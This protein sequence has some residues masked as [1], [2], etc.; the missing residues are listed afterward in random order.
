MAKHHRW[1]PG[2]IAG[3]WRL[4]ALVPRA[5]SKKS[6]SAS[7]GGWWR[8]ICVLCETATREVQPSVE[9]CRSSTG[10]LQCAAKARRIAPNCRH[11]GTQCLQLFKTKR[12][13]CIRCERARHRNGLCPDCNAILSK[14]LPGLLGIATCPRCF[15]KT[16]LVT[17]LRRAKR[18]AARFLKARRELRDLRRELAAAHEQLT[19]LRESR[20]VP[21]EPEQNRLPEVDSRALA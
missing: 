21:C 14:H 5:E 7:S 18:Q 1:S 10:C 17:A 13:E 3:G 8:A 4:L 19:A 12:T 9:I 15:V 2:E 16:G 11:C 20:Q 6:H